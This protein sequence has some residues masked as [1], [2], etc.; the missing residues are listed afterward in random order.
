[1]ANGTSISGRFAWDASMNGRAAFNRPRGDSDDAPRVEAAGVVDA[2]T[3]STNALENAPRAF[4]TAPTRNLV[5]MIQIK[6][7]Y[8]C[9]RTNLLPRSPTGQSR[10]RPSLILESLNP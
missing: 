7:C 2:H 6:K 5:D 9:R 10:I 1:M 8:P 3:A 4:P